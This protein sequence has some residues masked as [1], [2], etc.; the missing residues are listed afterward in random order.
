[1]LGI[2]YFRVRDTGFF[3]EF[4]K[5]SAERRRRHITGMG[6]NAARRPTGIS[7][8]N[9]GRR[10]DG[11]I[12]GLALVGIGKAL[13]GNS[14]GKCGDFPGLGIENDGR[15]GVGRKRGRLGSLIG[16]LFWRQQTSVCG[17]PVATGRAGNVGGRQ[18]T[19]WGNGNSTGRQKTVGCAGNCGWGEQTTHGAGNPGRGQETTRRDW[20]VAVVVKWTSVF[21]VECKCLMILLIHSYTQ[22]HTQ[23][24]TLS[25][26]KSLDTLFG[27][28]N[29]FPHFNTMLH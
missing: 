19:C 14:G 8:G 5:N 16:N 25:Q 24:C 2:A 27:S 4:T 11:N 9:T 13:G 17:R 29:T 28:V 15:W 12:T 21:R 22:T 23:T 10:L 26:N 6:G 18:S 7:T 3:S 20:V 1:M